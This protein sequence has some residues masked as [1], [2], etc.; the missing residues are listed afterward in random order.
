MILPCERL[1]LSVIVPVGPTDSAWLTLLPC[2]SCLG[3]Q[4]EVCIVATESAPHDL[5]V[6]LKHHQVT[7]EVRWIATASGRARQMNEGA[8]QARGDCLWFLHADSQFDASVVSK[9]MAAIEAHPEALH[10]FDLAF[11]KTSW[12]WTLLNEW[13]VR[14]RSRVLGL[15]F[16]DQGFCLQRDLFSQLGPFNEDVAYGEDHLLVWNC[17]CAGV[18]LRPV[19]TTLTTSPRKYQQR[20][21]LRTT[22]LHLWRTWRQALPQW[23]RFHRSRSK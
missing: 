19:G 14:F 16:G 13:G 9:L 20:G 3:H 2:L 22:A 6:L 17:H 18:P 4:S 7:A 5:T 12:D 1:Q 10:F 21:W 15:P 11:A 8:S 23:W